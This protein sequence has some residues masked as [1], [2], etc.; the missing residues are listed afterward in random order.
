MSTKATTPVRFSA[1]LAVA[2]IL[3]GC[4]ATRTTTAMTDTP[5]TNATGDAARSPIPLLS[6]TPSA[7]TIIGSAP[8]PTVGIILTPTS[9]P[10]AVGHSYAFHLLTHCGVNYHVDFDQ[11][12]W[13]AT[14]PVWDGSGNPPPNLRNP[15]QDGTMTLL[16]TDHAR[17]DYSGGAIPFRRLTGPKVVNGL[18]G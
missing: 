1:I 10:A 3:V 12:F 5:T 13:E 14:I 2:F 4:G 6:P 11:S 8:T 15:V 16:D 17:F 9:L 18:C 7:P